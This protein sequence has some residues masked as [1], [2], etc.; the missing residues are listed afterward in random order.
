MATRRTYQG[1]DEEIPEDAFG[2]DGLIGDKT[3]DGTKEIIKP[4]ASE[5][6]TPRLIGV[7]GEDESGEYGNT[8]KARDLTKQLTPNTFGLPHGVSTTESMFGSIDTPLSERAPDPFAPQPPITGMASSGPMRRSAS[9][10]SL[11]GESRSPSLFGR[12]DGL[13]GGGKG[14]AGAEESSGPLAPTEMMQ[15]L[16]Q[17]FRMQGGQ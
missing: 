15:K 6:T 17:L 13:L 9:A 7:P 4:P 11:Y 8:D 2:L 10:P 12:A 1:I 16:L 3:G 5:D 14:L